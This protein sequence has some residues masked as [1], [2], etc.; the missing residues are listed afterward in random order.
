M[1]QHYN[2]IQLI[3]PETEINYRFHTAVEESEFP[4]VHDFYEFSLVLKGKI[5]LSLDNGRF[6]LAAGALTLLRPGEIHAKRDLGGAQYINLAFH[7][8]IAEELFAY[9]DQRE[10][11]NALLSIKALLVAQLSPGETLLFKSRLE[12]MLLLPSTDPRRFRAE[13]RRLLLDSMA[14]WFIPLTRR[15]AANCPRWLKHLTEGLNN[16]ANLARGMAYLADESG[17]SPEYVSRAFQKYLSVAP[18][19][20]INAR[21]LNYAANMLLHSDHSILDIAYEAGFQSES[22]FFRNFRRE[23][24]LTP[25]QYRSLHLK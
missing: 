15:E 7:P 6:V 16:P 4:Q 9:L 12:S 10:E 2:T 25:R 23:Y 24:S 8:R 1:L 11:L 21:R 13:L 20:Y 18:L 5:E 19:A 17:K 14:D 22:S 3:D